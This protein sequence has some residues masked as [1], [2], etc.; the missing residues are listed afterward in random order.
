MSAALAT[1][2]AVLNAPAPAAA[3]PNAVAPRIAARRVNRRPVSAFDDAS[4]TRV[5]PHGAHPG[6]FF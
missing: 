4:F 6:P 3:N 2:G 1:D 5:P